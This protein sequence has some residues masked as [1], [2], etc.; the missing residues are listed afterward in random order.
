MIVPVFAGVYPTLQELT[1]VVTTASVHELELKVPPA[2][3][4][5]H[6][7]VPV[8]VLFV[9]GVESTTF[10]LRVIGFPIDVVAGFGSTVVVLLR[11][12][13]VSDDVP[14]LPA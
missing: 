8:G 4:S 11:I 3:P 5:L 13:D 1:P 9:P 10:P 14:E 6:D 7:I 2:P 12:V